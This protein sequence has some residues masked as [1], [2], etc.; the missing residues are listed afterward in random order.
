VCS[1]DAPD[2]NGRTALM[3]A[4]CLGHFQIVKLLLNNGANLH[5]VSKE[6]RTALDYASAFGHVEIV[7]LLLNE[8]ANIN[9]TDIHGGSAI[10]WASFYGHTD[11]VKLLIDKKANVNIADNNGETALMNACVLGHYQVA[12]MLLD[13]GAEINSCD[14]EGRTALIRASAQGHV[15]LV[16][17]LLDRG[18]NTEVIDYSGLTASSYADMAGQTN[19]IK[20]FREKEVYR[21]DRGIQ[22]D[23]SNATVESFLNGYA[24]SHTSDIIL[25]KNQELV[26]DIF[27][28][29]QILNDIYPYVLERHTHLLKDKLDRA[30]GKLKDALEEVASIPFPE[31][32]ELI[33][34]LLVD[35]EPLKGEA[36]PPLPDPDLSGNTY[37]LYVN[38][39]D[40]FKHLEEVWGKWLVRY[41][42]NLKHSYL[43]QKQ[44][45][46]RDP[47]FYEAL[48]N[49]LNRIPNEHIR[50]YIS[51]YSRDI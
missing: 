23:L 11:T 51:P 22:G 45:K 1:S 28:L 8:G 2:N 26:V 18:A 47:V 12:K 14:N 13:G 41:N 40:H 21:L 15:E 37:T 50:D 30:K 25:D 32:K 43:N 48:R 39:T 17:L 24:I 31:R 27:N 9:A 34:K 33:K 19:V 35:L 10:T 44:L 29:K 6:G 46:E 16:K 5:A 36:A 7:I 49:R 3:Y 38:R 42:P 20:L 4:S